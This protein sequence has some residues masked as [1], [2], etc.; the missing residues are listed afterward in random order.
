MDD[1]PL[2][3]VDDCCLTRLGDVTRQDRYQIGTRNWN[4][5]FSDELGFE[6]LVSCNSSLRNQERK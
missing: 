3:W 6:N 5:C 2:K 1:N 4:D